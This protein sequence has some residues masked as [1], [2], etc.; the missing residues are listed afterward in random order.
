MSETCHGLS[1]EIPNVMEKSGSRKLI[2]YGGGDSELS[3]LTSDPGE[4]VNPLPD[5]APRA[6]ALQEVLARP[7]WSAAEDKGKMTTPGGQ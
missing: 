6:A 4:A 3:D 7:G 1:S 2:N 5:Q